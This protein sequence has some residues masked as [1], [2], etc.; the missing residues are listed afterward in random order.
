MAVNMRERGR[1]ALDEIPENQ[2]PA[3]VRW[4]ELLAKL[5]D[6]Q[7]IEPEELWLLA[8]GVLE[9]IN[10]EIGKAKPINDWRKYLDEF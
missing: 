4:L 5:S 2:L 3:V 8:S 1:E 6:N 7:E 10:D 9:K